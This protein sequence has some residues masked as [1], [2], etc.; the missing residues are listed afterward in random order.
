MNA[1][2]AERRPSQVV[3]DL[4]PAAA[5][6]AGKD[7]AQKESAGR[8]RARA[9]PVLMLAGVGAVVVGAACFWYTGGRY[10]S[11]DDAY[12]SAAQVSVSTDVSGLV[13]EIRVKE[14]QPVKAGD[15]LF[16]IDPAQ[17]QNAL[18]NAEAALADTRLSI[19]STKVDYQATLETIAAQQAVV[20][21]DQLAFKR[22]AALGGDK[23]SV[24]QAMVD[25]ARLTLQS[26]QK[27]LEALQKQAQSQLAL[28]NG[29][30]DIPTESHPRYLEAKAQVDEA[31]RD[32]DHTYVKAPF[33]GIV[34]L[35]DS[36][37]PG[38]FLVAQT[39]GLTNQGAVALV[40]TEN[41]W[42]SAYLKETDLTYVEVGNPVEITVDTYP[43]RIW[44][45]AVDEISPA[46]ASDFSILPSENA[47]GN[48]VK[49]AQRIPVRI[50]IERDEDAPSLRAGMSVEV[51]I[52]TGH[53]RKL[54]DLF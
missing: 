28:L 29:N 3:V 49:V 17:Y 13:A 50:S 43:D 54:S 10:A 37:Q 40:S 32:L 46:S 14:D 16:R 8:W 38:V 26:D 39:A 25:Q 2:N 34:T 30:P 9:R 24:S 51:E 52:D 31:R 4:A 5:T 27:K 21:N 23:L 20:D 42:I 45:G 11:T 12:V 53:R 47:S 48:F 35:V 19:K 44:R 36:L 7:G 22:L 18:D 33:D 1:P 6:A 15:V 41:V